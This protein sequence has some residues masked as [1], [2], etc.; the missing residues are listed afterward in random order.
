V[1]CESCIAKG[2]WR[3]NDVGKMVVQ[4]KWQHTKSDSTKR[5]TTDKK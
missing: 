2:Q 5:T 1:Q 4:E 3:R